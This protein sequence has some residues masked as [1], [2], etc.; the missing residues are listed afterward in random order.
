MRDLKDTLHM[1]SSSRPRPRGSDFRGGVGTGDRAV[2]HDEG[3][4]DYQ[5]GRTS[6]CDRGN[7]ARRVRAAGR[8]H[9]GR[10]RGDRAASALKLLTSTFHVPDRTSPGPASSRQAAVLA[11]SSPP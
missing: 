3:D 2:A 11:R 8:D 1:I 4:R 5:G 10:A 7:I 6:A 9:R